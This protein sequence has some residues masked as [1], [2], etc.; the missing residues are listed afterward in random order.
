VRHEDT[1]SSSDGQR[2]RLQIEGTTDVRGQRRVRMRA[3]SDREDKS[4]Q[5]VCNLGASRDV[6]GMGSDAACKRTGIVM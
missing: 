1:L 4:A 6:Q 5:T 3:A 2:S